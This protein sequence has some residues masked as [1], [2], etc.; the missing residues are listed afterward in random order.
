MPF[1]KILKTLGIEQNPKIYKCFR[2]ESLKNINL[3]KPYKDVLKVFKL[4]EKRK[5][6]NFGDFTGI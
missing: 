2:E 4:F 5:K 6:R 3:I 1:L